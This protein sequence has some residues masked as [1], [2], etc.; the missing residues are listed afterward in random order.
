M[1]TAKIDWTRER[2]DL[3]A[4]GREPVL[5]EV[6]AFAFLMIDGQGDPNTAPQYRQAIE[7]LY[8]LSYT[9]KFSFTRERGVD[10]RVMPLEGLWWSPDMT[11]F[12]AARKD[13]WDWTAMIRQPEEL[14]EA[15]LATALAG[16]S[17]KKDLPAAARVRLERFAEGAA[18]Q[19]MHI[20][21]YAS[22]AP[23][24]ERLHA[25]IGEQGLRLAGKHHEIYLS[26]PRRAAPER[27]KTVVR[28]PVSRA[29][30]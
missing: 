5:V 3:Y 19:V 24:I 7:A 30:S 18:A 4:P 29:D 8:T 17:A 10:Y 26:D 25:F 22:E 9:I 28:Q 13:D 14:D 1:P 12:A 23:T 20:G 16:A 21:P 6:P 2:R 27:L 15:A 11:A